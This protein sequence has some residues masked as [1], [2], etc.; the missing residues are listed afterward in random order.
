VSLPAALNHPRLSTQLLQL[1]RRLSLLLAKL[2]FTLAP[3]W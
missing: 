1:R 3:L 2:L